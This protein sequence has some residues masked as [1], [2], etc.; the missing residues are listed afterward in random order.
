MRDYR[1]GDRVKDATG[2]HFI[3]AL[4]GEFV[5]VA[6]AQRKRLEIVDR[7]SYG[8]LDRAAERLALFYHTLPSPTY[9]AIFELVLHAIGCESTDLARAVVRKRER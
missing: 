4:D 8:A 5:D 7:A 9:A 3:I 6:V 2:N 1:P